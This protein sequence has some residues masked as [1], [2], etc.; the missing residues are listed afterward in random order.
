MSIWCPGLESGLRW[1]ISV[2]TGHLALSPPSL[3]CCSKA[4]QGSGG[5]PGLSGASHASCRLQ[6][7]P[8]GDPGSPGL[9]TQEV[10]LVGAGRAVERVWGPGRQHLSWKAGA[11]L[12]PHAGLW[13]RIGGPPGVFWKQG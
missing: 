6:M 7:A 8:G 3:S 1:E 4:V 13:G 2:F 9:A 10:S 11:L 5:P 12:H